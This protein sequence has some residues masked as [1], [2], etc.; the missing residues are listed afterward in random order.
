MP[1]W[2]NPTPLQNQALMGNSVHHGLVPALGGLASSAKHT[3]LRAARPVGKS[4][5]YWFL[6]G[7]SKQVI[8]PLQ[9][10]V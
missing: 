6:A 9:A 2:L 4:W 5:L 3:D 1:E 7:Q 8:W 10:M